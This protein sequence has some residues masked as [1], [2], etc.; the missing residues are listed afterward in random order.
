MVDTDLGMHDG[1]VRSTESANSFI[2]TGRATGPPRTTPSE[3]IVN[4]DG[5]GGGRGTS[6]RVVRRTHLLPLGGKT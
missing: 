6:T 3:V 4:G 5:G 1:V 2:G